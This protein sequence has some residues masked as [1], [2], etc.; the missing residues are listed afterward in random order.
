MAHTFEELKGMTVAQLRDI[1]KDV[2]DEALQGFMTM[3]KDHLLPAL[4]KALK[5]EGHARHVAKLAGK[6]KVKAQIRDLKKQRDAALAA[7][8]VKKL[9]PLRPLLH[10]LRR[11]LRKAA[12]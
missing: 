6:S 2:Q 12:K 1:A 4:C 3:H 8:D 7:H 11:K 10:A 5:I 9:A